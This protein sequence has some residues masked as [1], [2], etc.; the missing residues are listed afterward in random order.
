MPHL[1]IDAFNKRVIEKVIKEL[2]SENEHN[3]EMGTNIHSFP[4][5]SHF[6]GINDDQASAGALTGM[7]NEDE[8]SM[9]DTLKNLKELWESKFQSLCQEA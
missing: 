8:S 9:A 5:I 4:G 2:K 7:M 6:G 1:K 3:N